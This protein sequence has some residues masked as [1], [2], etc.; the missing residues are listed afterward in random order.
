MSI[1]CRKRRGFTLIEVLVTIGI[2]AILAGTLL[3]Y[4]RSG[5]S[6][7]AVFK[8]QATISGLINRAKAFAQQR[9]NTP[10]ACAFGIHIDGGG[11]STFQIFADKRINLSDPCVFQSGAFAPG[12]DF[13]YNGESEVI[14]S[15]TLD[16]RT[17]FVGVPT[18]GLDIV[19]IPPDLIATSSVTL[20][21]TFQISDAAG[22]HVSSITIEQGGQMVTH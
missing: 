9:L 3:A 4:N 11:A 8:D 5:E 18:E 7:I 6:Q 15:Y 19:F 21:V 10:L 14:G 17:H 22:A 2:S 1:E 13:R 20:P 12:L 16:S